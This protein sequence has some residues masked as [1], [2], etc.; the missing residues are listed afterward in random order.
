MAETINRES[1]PD[2]LPSGVPMQK[3]LDICI[4]IL[5]W[6]RDFYTKYEPYARETISVLNSTL[7]DLPGDF[8][9]FK[10]DYL[11]SNL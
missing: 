6:F 1:F 10:K 3:G 8:E 11:D 4:E 5:G 9:D 2:K 7:L